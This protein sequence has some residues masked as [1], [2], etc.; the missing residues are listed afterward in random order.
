MMEKMST[1]IK[2]TLPAT[3]AADHDGGDTLCLVHDSEKG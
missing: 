1:R 3:A 2:L